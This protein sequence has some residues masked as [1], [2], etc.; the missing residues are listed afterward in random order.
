VIRRIQGRRR[1]VKKCVVTWD[2]SER[3]V[4]AKKILCVF[5]KALFSNWMRVVC[6]AMWITLTRFAR[7]WEFVRMQRKKKNDTIEFEYVK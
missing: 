4:A 6:C 2:L 3:V 7:W 5:N 1:Q